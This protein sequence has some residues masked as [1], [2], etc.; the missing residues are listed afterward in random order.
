MK[1]PDPYETLRRLFGEGAT[2]GEEVTAPEL[3]SG[4]Y[5]PLLKDG[6]DLGLVS[7]EWLLAQTETSDG[8]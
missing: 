3:G 1:C 8:R 4:I 6:E 5:Y 2:L 7:R